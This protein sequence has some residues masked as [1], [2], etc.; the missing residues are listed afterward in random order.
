MGYFSIKPSAL[1]ISEGD[2][3]IVAQAGNC[4]N[5][6]CDLFFLEKWALIAMI[7]NS[8]MLFIFGCL[9]CTSRSAL[10]NIAWSQLQAKCTGIGLLIRKVLCNAKIFFLTVWRISFWTFKVLYFILCVS[11]PN[12]L[13]ADNALKFHVGFAV[14]NELSAKHSGFMVVSIT[15][16]TGRKLIILFSEQGLNAVF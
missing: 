5:R 16:E 11:A 9:I 4:G 1:F 7:W 6:R 2:S 10:Q 15:E 8:D 12:L 14:M 13:N 3:W